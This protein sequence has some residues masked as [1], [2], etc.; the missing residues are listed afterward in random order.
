MVRLKKAAPKN[1]LD[2]RV[3]SYKQRLLGINEE[4]VKDG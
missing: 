2:K 1:R 4:N 3:V